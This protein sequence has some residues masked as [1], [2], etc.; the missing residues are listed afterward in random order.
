MEEEALPVTEAEPFTQGKDQK[1]YHFSPAVSLQDCSDKSGE[2]LDLILCR[3]KELTEISAI[4][5]H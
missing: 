4:Q 5:N 2:A 1:Q 3:R